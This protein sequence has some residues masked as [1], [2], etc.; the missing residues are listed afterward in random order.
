[1][2]VLQNSTVELPWYWSQSNWPT[3]IA[4]TK[5]SRSLSTRNQTSH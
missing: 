3:T 1:V 5:C 2:Q 4:L